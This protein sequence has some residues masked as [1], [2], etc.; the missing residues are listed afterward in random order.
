MLAAGETDSL[1]ILQEWDCNCSPRTC[2]ISQFGQELCHIGGCINVIGIA[3]GI[4]L[5]DLGFKSW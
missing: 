1:C 5:D 4:T 2:G 3:T